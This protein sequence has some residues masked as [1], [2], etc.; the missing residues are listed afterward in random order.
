MR[1]DFY[2]I[3]VKRESLICVAKQRN[4]T[5]IIYRKRARVLSKVFSHRFFQQAVVAFLTNDT[6][7]TLTTTEKEV[8]Y[9]PH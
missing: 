4:K 1:I 6:Y 8:K 7:T 2:T 9:K 3:P 5:A